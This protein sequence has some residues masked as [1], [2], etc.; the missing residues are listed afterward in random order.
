[1]R[2]LLAVI[3]LTIGGVLF[4]SDSVGDDQYEIRLNMSV[5]QPTETQQAWLRKKSGWDNWNQTT[6]GWMTIMSERTGLPHRAW[7]AGI[8]FDGVDVETKHLNFVETVLPYFSIPQNQIAADFN[9]NRSPK[10]DR[11]FQKQQVNGYDVLLSQLQT[12][13]KE[14]KLVLWA[15]DWWADAYVPEGEILSDE[16]ILQHAIEGM[17]IQNLEFEWG[18]LAILP[19]SYAEGEFRLVKQLNIKGKIEGL[20]KNYDTWVDAHTGR[21][22]YRQ[23]QIVHHVGKKIVQPMGFAKPKSKNTN[24]SIT[25]KPVEALPIVSGQTNALAHDMYP[26]EA[27]VE[28]AMPHLR[29]DL[30]GQTY[31][32]NEN[33]GFS[34]NIN[35]ELNNVNVSL[36]GRWCTIYTNGVTPSGNYTFEN[37]YETYIVPGNTKEASAYRSTNLIHD[38]MKDWMPDFTDLDFSLTTNIDVDGECNAFYDGTSINFYD[39]GGGCNPT[40]LIA[41]VVYHEYGH[42][43]NGYF[44][45]SLGAWFNNGAMNEGYADFWA[46]S[47]G[48]IA[49]IG[50]GFYTDNNDGIRRYDIDPKVYPED[51]VGE[52]HADG[53]IIAGAWYDTHLLLGG[54]WDSTLE[55]FVDAYPG[56]QATATNGDEG[57]AFTDVLL[58]ALQADD[59]D[60]D[61]MNGT[62]NAAAIIEGFDIHG[63]SLF[64]YAEV[65]HIPAD[66]VE[67]QTTIEI[68]AEVE[69]VFPYNV[70]FDAVYLTYRNGPSD[71]WNQVVMDQ[72][73][74]T[75]T[76]LIDGEPSGTV[77]EYYMHIE[78]VFG[79]VSGVTPIA[80]NYENNSNLPYYLIVGCYP[81]L[82]NDSDDYA[83]FGFWDMGVPGD[84][85]TTGDW[86]ETIPVG[87]YA[88]VGNPESAVAPSA[89]HTVGFAGYCFLTG[90]SPG[91]DAGIGENDVD[92]GHT[93]LRS[94]IIDL[95]PYQNPV[96]EYWR[97]YVNAPSGGANPASDWWQVQISSDGGDTWQYL[98]NTSQQDIDWRRKAF[99]ISEHIELTSEFMMQFI[100]SDSTTVGEYLDGGSLVEG[101]LDDI[102]LYDVLPQNHS[103][104]DIE[105]SVDF[106]LMPNPTS[107]VVRLQNLFGLTPI[108]IYNSAG[109]LVYEGTS[110]EGGNATID[111]SGFANGIYTVESRNSMARRSAERL[112][113]IN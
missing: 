95:T 40:S 102:I 9:K 74:D 23:N 66:Y 7:G 41:D 89:D 29:L 113:I 59:D 61:L 111:V 32:S 19:D 22:W 87:S 76:F 37:G 4:A 60:G 90:V 80:S 100:A 53:E 82:I 97:W 26:Y 44:Y 36:E 79:G 21:I 107:D 85:A 77:I 28:L 8:D 75:F 81:Y 39:T 24:K 71:E 83:D 42:G 72:D 70:Y 51:I 49:E 68:E 67:E 43:I 99:N 98:E 91:A 62:P 11:I 58:D 55:L 93:T 105:H 101:A 2:G 50:K 35:Q 25:N 1:M 18:E 108:R 73:G 88:E 38:H 45:N 92:G 52:V 13:W 110:S 31:Y 27:A 69:I 30:N 65:E 94:P 14:G 86:E 112:E 63:I 109:A 48:D 56:L 46:M 84:N 96:M 16:V 20:V 5:N 104:S 15:L 54:N 6:S 12:K 106:M 10:H 47:L 57:Q 64:S 34:T 17:N 33:G 78:D 103:T 3:G